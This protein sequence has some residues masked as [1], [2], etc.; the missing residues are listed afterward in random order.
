MSS[1]YQ[2][3]VVVDIRIGLDISFSLS[4]DNKFK[5]FAVRISTTAIS[6]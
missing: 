2:L 5:T 4:T 6:W 3:I 1:T